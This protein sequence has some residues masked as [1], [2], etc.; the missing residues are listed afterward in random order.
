MVS[1]VSPMDSQ[2][3]LHR[4]SQDGGEGPVPLQG[5]PR[6]KQIGTKALGHLGLTRNQFGTEVRLQGFDLRQCTALFKRTLKVCPLECSQHE[7]QGRGLSSCGILCMEFY[8]Q[9]CQDG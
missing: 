3:A 1:S 7:K 9:G 2:S 6:P 5:A 8:L 4:L